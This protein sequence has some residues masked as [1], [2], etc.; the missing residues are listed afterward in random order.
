M[1]EGQEFEGGKSCR[2]V[3]IF[4]K[5]NGSKTFPLDVSLNDKV[6]DVVRR[7]PSNVCD[8]KCDVYVTCAGRVSA[9]KK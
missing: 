2:T 4:V 7:I 3:Q 1:E 9:W 6:S 5:V 8:R